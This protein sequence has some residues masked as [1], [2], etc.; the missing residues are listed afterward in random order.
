M[1]FYVLRNSSV[2]R[3]YHASM[4][5]ILQT[6]F[7]FINKRFLHKP[8]P[9]SAVAFALAFF[10]LLYYFP[11]LSCPF[12]RRLFFLYNS[13][14]LLQGFE[15]GEFFLLNYG[16]PSPSQ[17]GC[18]INC[19]LCSLSASSPLVEHLR[20]GSITPQ[21]CRCLRP[22]L[23]HIDFTFFFFLSRVWLVLEQRW[24]F[25]TTFEGIEGLRFI[26]FTTYQLHSFVKR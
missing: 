6:V 17:T 13:L 15:G 11:P 1:I 24:P 12:C 5:Y 10:F 25:G 20:G 18:G 23:V 22:A 3:T 21:K 7:R 14:V 16:F 2:L 8:V 4:S 19:L 26:V 9:P